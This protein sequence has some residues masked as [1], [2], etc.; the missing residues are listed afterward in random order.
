M[1]I[2]FHGT[3]NWQRFAETWAKI[4]AA[5][6]GLEIVP[7]SGVS[8]VVQPGGSIRDDLVIEAC[9]EHG[10]TMCFTGLRLFHH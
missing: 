1:N 6:E 8:Y 2:V 5:K 7:G 3:P 4:L 9:N 10:I